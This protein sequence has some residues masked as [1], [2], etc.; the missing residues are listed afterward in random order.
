MTDTSVEVIAALVVSIFALIVS[1][2]GIGLLYKQVQEQRAA[3]DLQNRIY[4][5]DLKREHGKLLQPVFESWLGDRV[6]FSSSFDKIDHA[7]KRRY[8][9]LVRAPS[10]A[11][12][13]DVITDEW[14]Y[15]ALAA[16]HLQSASNSLYVG[17]WNSET[18]FLQHQT[19]Y[20]KAA[21]R[22]LPIVKNY[23][24]EE[25]KR[26]FPDLRESIETY[27]TKPSCNFELLL[28]VFLNHLL[29]GFDISFLGYDMNPRGATYELS[30]SLA[31]GSMEDS[32]LL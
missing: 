3:T 15:E 2:V 13:R 16:Q 19:A 6:I 18:D 8:F 29:D 7:V 22:V 10:P 9:E 5:T 4:Y 14:T 25:I 11:S 23:L 20:E 17:S 30:I 12:S 28:Y 32:L 27:G 26:S 24:R 31:R 21:E 1:I